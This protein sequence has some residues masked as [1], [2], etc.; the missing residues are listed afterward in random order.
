M[1]DTSGLRCLG[2]LP[3]SPLSDFISASGEKA[4]KVKNLSHGYNDFRQSRLGA[5]FFT[6]LFSL[7]I[8]FKTSQPVFKGDRDGNNGISSRIRLNPLGDFR[9]ILVLLS[10]VVPL[11]EIDQV[12]YGFGGQEEKRIYNFNL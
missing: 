8:R 7:G 9:K 10:D 11:A 5:Q 6:F 3:D 4:A 12:N 1:N 2:S